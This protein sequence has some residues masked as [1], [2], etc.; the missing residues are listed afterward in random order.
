MSQQSFRSTRQQASA[1]ALALSFTLG[2]LF[3]LNILAK[4]AERSV[5]M[6]ASAASG[7][8]VMSQ[9]VRPPRV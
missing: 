2:T 8:K 7:A 6:A 9:G 3:S 4:P 1:L 5:T